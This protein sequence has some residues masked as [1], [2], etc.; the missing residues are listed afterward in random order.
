M[1]G[2]LTPQEIEEVINL[3]YSY[4]DQLL[5]LEEE[6]E[7]NGEIPKGADYDL[8]LEQIR[9]ETQKQQD[10]IFSKYELDVEE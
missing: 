2:V 6:M 3:E 8:R 10:L 1:R 4:Y 9:L 7:Q 5:L